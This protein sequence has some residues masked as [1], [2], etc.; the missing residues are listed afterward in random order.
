MGSWLFI[1]GKWKS[2][3]FSNVDVVIWPDFGD[4]NFGAQVFGHLDLRK[5]K[6]QFVMNLMWLYAHSVNNTSFLWICLV[7][8]R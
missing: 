1:C 7:A 6:G 4:C 8:D 3:T 5:G 2:F